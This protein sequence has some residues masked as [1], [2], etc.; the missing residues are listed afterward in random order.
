ME[1]LIFSL[2]IGILIVDYLLGRLL[3]GLNASRMGDPVPQTLTGLYDSEK[4]QTQQRYQKANIRFDLVFSTCSLLIL[5]GFLAL[6]GFARVHGFAAAVTANPLWQPLIFFGVLLLAQDLLTTPFELYRTF[7]IEQQF[8][9]NKTSPRL[10]WADKLKGWLLMAVVGGTVLVLMTWFYLR[11]TDR[12]WLY[13]W[14][15]VSGVALFFTL[16]YSNLI[17]PLFNRQTE[18]EEGELKSAIEGFARRASFPVKDLYV[19]D[20]SKRST[21][22]NAYFAG[23][24]RKKRIV[25]F[26]T[27]IKD[28]ST[29]EVVAV[30][31]HE[32][33]H[34][35]KKHTLQAMLISIA[36]TGV[37]F[38]LLSLF[39][40]QEVF[41]RALGVEGAVFHVGLVAF[42]LLYGPVS[43]VTGLLVNGWSRKN[44]YQ[45]DAF[46]A[47]HGSA[48]ALVSALKKLSLN[49]LSNLTPHPAYVFFHYSHPSLYQRVQALEARTSVS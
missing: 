49:H 18:L 15:L 45:A 48:G 35:K 28:L 38:Y 1:N 9:F 24:G 29:D 20:G 25:L 6:S 22:A 23:L 40:G 27:L 19:L 16:F 11:T 44:E 14:L 17:V 31:A 21:K 3:D 47:D 39:L 32:I 26:D 12:F 4:Y 33:G 13:G 37:V 36:Q 46:A 43:L 10:F 30:L 34:F 7:V 5:L 8:G 41:L 42:M 2:M